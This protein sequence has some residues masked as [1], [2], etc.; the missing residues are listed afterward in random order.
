MSHLGHSM[1]SKMA[2]AIAVSI[3]SA[4]MGAD[5]LREDNYDRYDR[6]VA[7]APVFASKIGLTPEG[8]LVTLVQFSHVFA[9]SQP[10]P[11][12]PRLASRALENR[13]FVYDGEKWQSTALQNHFEPWQHAWEFSGGTSS[14]FFD[15]D[16]AGNPSLIALNK[17]TPAILSYRENEWRT[18]WK[19]ATASQSPMHCYDGKLLIDSSDFFE[20]CSESMGVVRSNLTSGNY[21]FRFRFKITGPDNKSWILRDDSLQSQISSLR[22]RR[23]TLDI[24]TSLTNPRSGM[25]IDS[26]R[27]T[28][29]RIIRRP[30]L[31]FAD[32]LNTVKQVTLPRNLWPMQIP[33]NSQAGFF[34][35]ANSGLG[36][37][38]VQLQGD[39]LVLGD[40]TFPNL[41]YS[42]FNSTGNC[43]LG[44]KAITTENDLDHDG[45]DSLP[46]QPP[47]E[48]ETSSTPSL[49]GQPQ[50]F[51]FHS[52]CGDAPDSL[53]ISP[54][55]ISGQVSAYFQADHLGKVWALHQAVPGQAHSIYFGGVT[56]S[57]QVLRSPDD[58]IAFYMRREFQSRISHWDGETWRNI[59]WPF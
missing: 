56:F 19:G 42:I 54:D 48:I 58:S 3:L 45:S 17:I 57:N 6:K 24:I 9:A 52:N 12:E 27:L 22:I 46:I 15:Y 4:C 14:P 38:T 49:S 20:I 55:S 51:V 33:G 18:V 35:E 31:S 23:D 29:N 36:Y 25:T 41:N 37:K 30:G 8:H 34:S 21:L 1:V 47:R 16:I 40:S 5:P 26:S 10:H 32:S 28:W 11:Y 53:R 7:V 50:H 13:L 2:T 43:L 59:P 39:S 44:Y